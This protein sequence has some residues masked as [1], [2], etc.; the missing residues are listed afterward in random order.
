MP[1]P[2]CEKKPDP[3]RANVAEGRDVVGRP[4]AAQCVQRPQ[5]V[6]TRSAAKRMR[7]FAP[8]GPTIRACTRQSR[9]RRF[10]PTASVSRCISPNSVSSWDYD[11]NQTK[12][13]GRRSFLRP[14]APCL[15][16][17]DFSSAS[18]STG[19]A[20]RDRPPV[21][22]PLEEEPVMA[23]SSCGSWSGCLAGCSCR[24]LYP[25]RR[26]KGATAGADT[27]VRK[28]RRMGCLWPVSGDEALSGK[29]SCNPGC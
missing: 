27:P 19:A 7:Q 23:L 9:R 10:E 13:S 3:V 26:K 25:T 6:V 17:T 11:T 29:A 2:F 20:G 18:V 21:T 12:R 24:C 16:A 22:L 15:A 8:S 4:L 5:R 1:M 14:D 28:Q